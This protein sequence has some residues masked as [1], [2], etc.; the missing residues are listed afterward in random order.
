MAGMENLSQ[1]D[2]VGAAEREAEGAKNEVC[3]VA[4]VMG[5]KGEKGLRQEVEAVGKGLGEGGGRWELK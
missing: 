3:T 1:E 4:R 5:S 2:L